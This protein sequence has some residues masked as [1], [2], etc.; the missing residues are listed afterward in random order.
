M[1][2]QGSIAMVLKIS[3]LCAVA[4]AMVVFMAGGASDPAP[5]LLELNCGES[6]PVKLANGAERTVRLLDYR[7]CTEPYYESANKRTAQAVASA[8]VTVDV[9]GVTKKITGGPFRMP[10]A[11]NG[12]SL[13]VACT[14]GWT[15]GIEPDTL[16]KDVRLEA[17]D[18]SR[19]WYSGECFAFPVRNYR[20]HAMNYQHT[21]LALAVNQPRLYY[22]RGEDFGM[23]PDLERALAITD[24]AVVKVPG[25]DGDGDS[26]I[27][28]LDTDAG[29]RFLYAHLNAP[30][31][32]RELRPGSRLAC[33][34]PLGL[35]GN[36]WAGHLVT[37]PHLHVDAKEERTGRYVNTFPL[38]TAAYRTSFP[39]EPMPIAGGWRHVH[40]GGSITLDGSLSQAAEGSRLIGFDWKF[41]DGSEAHGCSFTRRYDE[42]GAYSE[43]LT[44]TDDR[45]RKDCDFVEVF[46][47]SPVQ[48]TP[49]PY[50]WINYYPVRGIRPGTEVRFLTRYANLR[51]LSIDYGDG[52][53]QPWAESTTHSY[54]RRGQYVVTIRGESAGAGP[55]LFHVRV[56]VE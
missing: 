37:D 30:H 33:G 6:A 45:G 4:C 31:I 18:A 20:W 9:D 23:I 32:R 12:I 42:L 44:I 43:Q 38:I 22:H 16:A 5:V 49:P 29:M 39:D 28:V 26:N 50:A 10:V 47:L 51:N 36:T 24:A 2:K 19:P 56:I 53:R 14:R 25:L 52:V 55:G 13:L 27:I 35:T 40:A 41:A 17:S 11:V 15:G 3:P 46:V 54:E 1:R 34:E 7:E 8:D 48:K 21:Y